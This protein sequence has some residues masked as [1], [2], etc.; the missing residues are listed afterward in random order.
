MTPEQIE[1]QRKTIVGVA[2]KLTDVK[3][4]LAVCLLQDARGEVRSSRAAD[5]RRCRALLLLAVDEINIALGEQ[6]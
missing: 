3:H 4:R 5:L 2:S 1:E 6:K